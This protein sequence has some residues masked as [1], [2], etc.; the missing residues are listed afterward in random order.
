MAWPGQM[1]LWV[2]QVNCSHALDNEGQQSLLQGGCLSSQ[3]AAELPTPGR[4]VARRLPGPSASCTE[5]PSVSH[6]RRCVPAQGLQ[7]VLF[8]NC[9]QVPNSQM[10]LDS[11]PSPQP[12]PKRHASCTWRSTPKS[13]PSLPA[14]PY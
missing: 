13:V 5:V 1:A 2:P 6:Q 3:G 9:Q 10:S 8:L 12:H 4:K 11:A 7:V 14:E